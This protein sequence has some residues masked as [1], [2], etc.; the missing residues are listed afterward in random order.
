MYFT[1]MFAYIPL[2]AL[3]YNLCDYRNF[4]LIL[5]TAVSSPPNIELNT[6]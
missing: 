2:L 3:E 5:F 1:Y 6:Y 4:Y